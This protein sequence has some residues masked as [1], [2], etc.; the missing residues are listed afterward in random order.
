MRKLRHQKITS[1]K[2]VADHESRVM[3]YRITG[4]EVEEAH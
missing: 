2:E 3:D 1:Y 4:Q